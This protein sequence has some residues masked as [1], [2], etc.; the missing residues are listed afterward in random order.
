MISCIEYRSVTLLNYHLK[1][2]N[3]ILS[4]LSLEVQ[5]EAYGDLVNIV[6]FKTFNE[7]L[8]RQM[9]ISIFVKENFWLKGGIQWWHCRSHCCIPFL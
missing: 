9:Y 6:K 7:K 1:V 8:L 2:I 3:L 4:T 5:K